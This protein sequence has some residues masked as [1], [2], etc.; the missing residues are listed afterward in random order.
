MMYSIVKNVLARIII[1][2]KYRLYMCTTTIISTMYF[3]EN[4]TEQHY[5]V[6]DL[7]VIYARL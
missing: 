3:T 2:I 6:S 7:K 1:S 4:R 5:L